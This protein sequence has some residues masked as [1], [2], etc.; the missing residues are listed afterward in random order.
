MWVF[1][2]CRCCTSPH[3]FLI[4]VLHP[5][6]VSQLHFTNA[7]HL[8]NPTASLLPTSDFPPTASKSNSIIPFC[9]PGHC[10]ELLLHCL[11]LLSACPA[12]QA[13]SPLWSLGPH[14]SFLSLCIEINF[15]ML[16]G[17]SAGSCKSTRQTNLSALIS[18]IS[19]DCTCTTWLELTQPLK[20][21]LGCVQCCSNPGSSQLLVSGK[22][23]LRM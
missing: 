22:C 23:L 15:F 5:Q 1:V 12:M 20:A 21:V 9:Y 16:P 17:P 19:P 3:C 2:H 10:F 4:P 18:D 7:H 8:C 13:G 11:L 14:I 6:P